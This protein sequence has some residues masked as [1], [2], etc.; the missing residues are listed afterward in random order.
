MNKVPAL[1]IIYVASIAI[2]IAFF[3]TWVSHITTAGHLSKESSPIG[4]IVSSVTGELNKAGADIK[5]KRS[6]SGFDVPKL[7]AKGKSPLLTTIGSLFGINTRNIWVL[8]FAI[9]FIPLSGLLCAA[10][11]TSALKTKT[12]PLYVATVYSGAVS[13]GGFT[14]IKMTDIPALPVRIEIGVGVWL[15][16]AAFFV[17]FLACILLIRQKRL[18]PSSSQ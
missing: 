11:A 12:W 1:P 2:V 3:L 5:M 14:K 16:F 6:L 10:L 13:I 17:M 9:Y 4:D 8:S 15:M 7:A 18:A